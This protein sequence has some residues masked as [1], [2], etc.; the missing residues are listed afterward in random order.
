MA[1]RS[2][3]V[4]TPQHNKYF[5]FVDYGTEIPNPP[6]DQLA[7]EALV[8]LLVGTRSHWKCPIGYFLGNKTNAEIQSK[9]VS[10]ALELAAEAGLKVWSVTADG[11]AVNIKTFELLGCKFVANYDDMV[12][13]FKHPTTSEEVFAILD[14][15]HMLKLARNALEAYGSFVD[16]NGNTIKWQH[17]RIAEVA[18][19]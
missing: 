12:T 7:S 17:K 1:I 16:G 2:Q 10:K 8:F 11:T 19:E 13:S 4:W 5:S 6:S 15:C 9:L 3:T 14:P 18:R